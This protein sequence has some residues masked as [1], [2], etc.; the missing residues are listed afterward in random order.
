VKSA[1]A[2]QTILVSSQAGPVQARLMPRLE[3]LPVAFAD[4]GSGPGDALIVAQ[5]ATDDVRVGMA[6]GVRWIQS[7]AT[8]VET[9]LIPEVVQSEVVV[10]NSS[11][12]TAGPVA[13]YTFGM[14][15]EHAM[16]LRRT[17]QSQQK[18]TWDRFFHDRLEGSTLAVVGLGPIGQRVAKLGR[19]FGMRVLGVRRRPEAGPAGCDAVFAPARLA[20]VMAESDYVVL[21]AAATPATQQLVDRTALAAAK[22]GCLIV[23]VGR[24]ELVDHAAL[25]DAVREGRVRAALDALPE[26]PL[27]PESPWWDAPGTTISA[28]VAVWTRSMLDLTTELVADNV[29]RFVQGRPLLN[30]VDKDLGYVPLDPC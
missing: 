7:L 19:A 16:G 28:H 18:H 6:S 20:E 4:L 5:Y 24:A 2:A 14:I 29:A 10:T 27:P 1:T 9:V 26:E 13:E 15:L 12:A 8:G 22:P 30:V 3:G 21:L 11:G 23:N 25:L 17:A